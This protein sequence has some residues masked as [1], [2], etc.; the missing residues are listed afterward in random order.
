[1][2]ECEVKQKTSLSIQ[3]P[4]PAQL[5]ISPLAPRGRFLCR[6]LPGAKKLTPHQLPSAEGVGLGQFFALLQT[7]KLRHKKLNFQFAFRGC[8]MLRVPYLYAF[9]MQN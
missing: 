2:E 1:M 8:C 9:A 5:K 3:Q 4:L 7:A 6:S